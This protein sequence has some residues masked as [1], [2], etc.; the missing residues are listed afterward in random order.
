MR[1][2]VIIVVMLY[3]FSTYGQTGDEKAIRAVIDSIWVAM[4]RSDSALLR[5][6][7]TEDATLV[8]IYRSKA[9]GQVLERE[10]LAPF[11][12]SV[13]TPH[14]DV[15]Y[16]ETWNYKIQVNADLASVW[17]DYAFY[18]GN[19][20]SHCGVNAFH[21][22]KSE[23]GWRIFHLSDTRQRLNCEVPASIR[24]KHK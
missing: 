2:L 21:L 20:L 8:T 7:F 3:T 4:Q 15:W 24:E 22:H 1:L 12:K 6:S 16:E 14:E 13:G 17:C 18:L 9:K 11:L 23:A 5:K 10:G 19:T